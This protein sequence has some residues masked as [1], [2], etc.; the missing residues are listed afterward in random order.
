MA[1]STAI[2]E[3]TRPHEITLPGGQKATIRPHS[4]VVNTPKVDLVFVE[5]KHPEVIELDIGTIIDIVGKVIDVGKK[6]FVNG[7]GGGGGGGGCKV[8]I[9]GHATAGGGASIDFSI[10]CP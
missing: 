9:S 6:I 2:A 8:S 7:G 4:L 10:T 1:T 3:V 5:P